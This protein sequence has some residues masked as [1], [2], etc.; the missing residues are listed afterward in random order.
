M[1]TEIDMT[2]KIP[3][4]QQLM[5]SIIR[6]IAKQELI[7]GAQLPSVRTLADEL[8]VNMHTVAKAYSLLKDK[9]FLSVHRNKGAVVNAQSKFAADAVYL[10]DLKS[11]LISYSTEAACRGVKAGEWISVC[12]EVY[13]ELFKSI[14]F[15]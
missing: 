2:S 3:I 11:Q 12:N 15:M 5:H 9:G 8:G 10:A 14:D 13:E 7:P 4:Y 6:S 1:F